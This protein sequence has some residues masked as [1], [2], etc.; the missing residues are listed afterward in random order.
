LITFRDRE[1]IIYGGLGTFEEFRV[2]LHEL[3]YH[4]NVCLLASYQNIHITHHLLL[5]ALR[6]A[7]HQHPA[8]SVQVSN[9]ETAKPYFV[10]LPSIDLN[11]VIE[12]I[13]A[14]ETAEE[15]NVRIDEFLSAQHS[16]GFHNKDKPLWRVVVLKYVD[17]DAKD[18][19]TQ[20]ESVDIAFVWHHVI[21]DGKSGLAVH[22][23]I[24][25]GL[26]TPCSP[27]GSSL[28]R[29]SDSLEMDGKLC[30]L[31]PIIESPSDEL[32]P[33]LEQLFS[34]PASRSTKIKK[35]LSVNFG[36]C[37]P[38]QS[39]SPENLD[40]QKWSGSVYH[41]K[42]SIKTLIR[43]ITIPTLA[44]NHL[45]KLCHAKGT[46]VTAFL[47]TV[48]GRT[49]SKQYDHKW[50]LRCATAISMRRFMDPA[51]KIGEREMGLWVSAFH[52]ELGAKELF[53][54]DQSKERFWEMS[55]KNRKRILNEI[56]KGDTDLGIGALRS[57]PDFR[58][59]LT[60]KIG[61][62]RDDSFAVTN[63]GV[64]NGESNDDMSD[65]KG[66]E[67]ANIRAMI[68]SQS[69]HVNGSAL[70]FCIMSVKDGEMTI[71]VSWQEGTVPI[72]ETECIARSLKAELMKFSEG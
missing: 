15:C 43:H 44:T 12:Y 47:Q 69:C 50:R 70:Q 33:S 9:S 72:K 59:N 38:L 62:K 11:E 40:A 23:S 36:S 52:F 5:H 24:L 54:I 8:L 58:R 31:S 7:I 34:M 22:T 3:G 64:F 67:Q 55:R 27:S 21:G 51:L 53:D 6:H 37:F 32:F 29:R 17:E 19:A 4:N 42:A 14:P 10:R 20:I 46:T 39:K 16:L 28:I 63:L 57:I 13:D 45:V 35:W 66:S 56:K 26:V 48:I 2:T 60:G 49:I 65:M 61:K 68:F 71:G 41:D 25:Q 30:G 18:Q 1:L